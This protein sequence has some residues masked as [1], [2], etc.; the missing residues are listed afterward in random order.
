MVRGSRV[1][2]LI[3]SSVPVVLK[4]DQASQACGGL[5]VRP[6]LLFS[7]PV[8]GTS[9]QEE[10][11]L[12]LLLVRDPHFES[13]EARCFTEDSPHPQPGEW[14]AWRAWATSCLLSPS[15]A[16][17]KLFQAVPSTSEAC[18]QRAQTL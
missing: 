14:L 3:Q 18:Q 5:V 16:P 9:S 12:L 11:L 10:E 8:V 4:L 1:S 6:G 2:L 13:L 15:K 17:R 7:G